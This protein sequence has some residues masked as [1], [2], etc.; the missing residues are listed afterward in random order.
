[1]TQARLVS[2][3][4]S[5]V[6]PY[7]LG[8]LW[9]V[10]GLSVIQ[11]IFQVIGVTSV[12]PFFSIAADPDKFY[13]STIG[14]AIVQYFPTLDTA[15]LLTLTGGAS[16]A[17][18]LVSSII[19]V[20]AQYAR[21]EYAQGFAHWLRMTVITQFANRP[22]AYFL[23]SNPA[24]LNK[25]L[26]ADVQQFTSSVL[27]S[28][29]DVVTGL[30]TIT[31][32]V[33]TVLAV[34]FWVSIGALAVVGGFYAL[35]FVFLA[36][37]RRSVS[38]G[39]KEAVRRT[40][41]EGL[42][43]INGIKT[44]RVYGAEAF[45]IQRFGRHSRTAARR[46]ARLPV[47]IAAPKH[48]I[49]P[50]VFGSLI[51][52]LLV[53]LGRGESLN[54]AIPVLSVIALAGYRM[55]PAVQQLYARL[56]QITAMRHTLDEVYEELA[57]LERRSR[58]LPPQPAGFHFEAL[59]FEDVSFRYPRA[60][61]PVIHHLDLVIGRGEAVAICGES[62]AGK[63]T[64]ID[65]LLGLQ[66]PT[67]G[68]LTVNG[69]PLSADLLRSY[70]AA[71]GYVPQ[72]CFLSNESIRAN[73][74]FGV[75]DEDVDEQ[76]LRR[77]CE[78]ARI[79]DTIENQLEHGFATIVGDRGAKLSGGQRQ[80]VALARALY[81]DPQLLILDEATSAL[82]PATEST[83]SAAIDALHGR[84]TLVIIAHR[85]TSVSNID[86]KYELRDGRLIARDQ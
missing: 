62:G 42:G 13:A 51:V 25:K 84:V 47:Y 39:M 35:T 15:Q 29:L 23:E 86:R 71:V 5:L 78:Q 19:S 85:D 48:L 40:H 80:R 60:Q 41:D 77:A 36:G 33:L 9:A 72:D 1:M 8:K 79:L 6:R 10:L 65:L 67:A 31:F 75:R 73:I 20:M 11:G 2:R 76:Q 18:L 37:R 56:S 21:A 66:T 55:I 68:R 50:L 32:L 34:D 26:N 45:Y 30:A 27:L 52:Y 46:S 59:A 22:Y 3:T 49:E 14:S 44:Y 61:T 83:V 7:G 69:Q 53:I 58:D 63:S 4:Y 16:L 82:D 57:W 81:R 43:L 74:A 64:F 70:H 17:L 12:F 28:L 24:V 38:R 54:D